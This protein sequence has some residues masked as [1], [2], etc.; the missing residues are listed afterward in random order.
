MVSTRCLIKGSNTQICVCFLYSIRVNNTQHIFS[1]TA[2]IHIH[3]KKLQAACSTGGPWAIFSL[4]RI[5]F[6]LP[7]F[8]RA[9]TLSITGCNS[10]QSLLASR[11]SSSFCFLSQPQCR[12]NV[13]Y[14]TVR[15]A[16]AAWAHSALLE[17]VWV[18]RGAFKA[19]RVLLHGIVPAVGLWLALVQPVGVRPLAP[20][21][22]A[23]PDLQLSL[24]FCWYRNM[25][26][27]YKCDM[28]LF[29]PLFSEGEI[30][31]K[32]TDLSPF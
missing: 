29:S 19:G 28:S 6:Q 9:T 31:S 30:N 7:G 10:N 1:S 4:Q 20:F 12:G 24:C 13:G 25:L 27:L 23:S 11:P 17:G 18:C 14:S 3:W 5:R 2:E 21:K 16:Q 22:L 26:L 8:C 15:E 32:P